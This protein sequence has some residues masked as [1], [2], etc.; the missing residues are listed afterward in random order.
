MIGSIGLIDIAGV[1]VI[2]VVAGL[3]IRADLS[4]I[5]IASFRLIVFADLAV[6]MIVDFGLIVFA[7]L[8]LIGTRRISQRSHRGVKSRRADRRRTGR[9]GRT[10]RT[11][12]SA[13]NSHSADGDR[14]NCQC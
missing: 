9:R 14:C 13:R 1:T 10:G 12:K 6:I 4:L 8:A 5:M 2:M 3:I 7:D 11:A